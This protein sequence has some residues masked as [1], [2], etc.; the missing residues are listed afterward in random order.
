MFLKKEKLFDLKE[1]KIN[2]DINI[3]EIVS[4]IKGPET[5]EMGN[6]KIKNVLKYSNFLFIL[7]INNI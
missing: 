7:I 5:K 1:K 2:C 4:T 3:K 6:N